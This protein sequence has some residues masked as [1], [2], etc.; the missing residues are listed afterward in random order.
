MCV[1]RLDTLL[2]VVV[3]VVVV[4]VVAVAVAVAVVCSPFL[5]T[6]G[7]WDALPFCCLDFI[8][9]HRI[10]LKHYVFSEHETVVP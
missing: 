3:V 4:V 2:F 6:L 10:H 8:A 5:E 7:N 9:D 1:L